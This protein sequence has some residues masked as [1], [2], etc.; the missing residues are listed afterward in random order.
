ML[1]TEHQ[2]R[3]V[4]IIDKHITHVLAQGG[5]FGPAWKFHKPLEFPS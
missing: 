1:L 4:G 2:T 3:L 5:G